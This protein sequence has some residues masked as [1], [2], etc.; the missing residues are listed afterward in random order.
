MVVL[1]FQNPYSA[2]QKII[3]TGTLSF[4]FFIGQAF[5]QNLPVGYI[6][7]YSQ[8]TNRAQLINTIQTCSPDLW[9]VNHDNAGFVLYPLSP[10]SLSSGIF[11]LN[12][13]V[14]RNMVFGEYIM[15]FEFN[16]TSVQNAD[17]SGFCFLGPVKSPDTYYVFVFENN[18]VTFYY[19]NKG[20]RQKIESKSLVPLKKTWN[21]IRVIRDILNRS[22]T[23][24]LN[25][26]PLQQVTFKHPGLVMGFIGFGT[27]NAQNSIRNINVW[28]PTVITDSTFFC[29]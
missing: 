28:A 3:L 9:N 7:Y 21:S 23:F 20:I 24:T 19:I 17:S 29:K 14:I 12:M 8:K 25:G 4:L 16:T 15:E 22:I 18:R 26:D 1:R 13:G 27:I 6:N 10:D 2:F 11:E 5:T